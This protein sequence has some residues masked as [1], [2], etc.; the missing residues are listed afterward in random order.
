MLA[1]SVGNNHFHGGYHRETPF[2]KN[3]T[4]DALFRAKNTIYRQF[5]G[6]FMVRATIKR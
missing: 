3:S 6:T 2:L 4:I 1:Y 5:I